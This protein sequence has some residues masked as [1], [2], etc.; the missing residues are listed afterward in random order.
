M[1]LTGL[2]TGGAAIQPRR[3][4]VPGIS[5]DRAGRG[6]TLGRV[7]PG[8]GRPEEEAHVAGS[9]AGSLAG[10]WGLYPLLVPGDPLVH[11]DD[12]DRLVTLMT[13]GRVFQCAGEADGWLRLRCGAVTGRVRPDRY[14]PVPAPAF[15]PG[16][17]VREREGARR[18][19]VVTTIWWHSARARPMFFISVGGRERTRRYFDDELEPRPGG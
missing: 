10:S 18:A 9:L 19:G 2:P 12:A 8:R 16:D 4:R 15:Q 1:V 17:P 7:P 6:A 14:H 11:P 5:G 13:H 3:R